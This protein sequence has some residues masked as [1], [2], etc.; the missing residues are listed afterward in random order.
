M[1]QH[2]RISVLDILSLDASMFENSE[3]FKA[4]H[5]QGFANGVLV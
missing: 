3:Y 1:Q 2:Q 4:S 5:S